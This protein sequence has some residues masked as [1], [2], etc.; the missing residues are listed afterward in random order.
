[1]QGQRVIMLH[2]PL[3]L[4]ILAVAGAFPDRPYDAMLGLEKG[5]KQ[6]RVWSCKLSGENAISSSRQFSSF[7]GSHS[8]GIGLGPFM[9]KSVLHQSKPSG[10][11][12]ASGEY[13]TWELFQ[14]GLGQQL[15]ESKDSLSEGARIYA[16]KYNLA[17]PGKSGAKPGMP[18]VQSA[19]LIPEVL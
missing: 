2:A 3:S 4:D 13:K 18:G 14:C 6:G 7:Q 11:S 1:M 9:P 10:G 5:Q 8:S 16:R 15:A 12:N 17:L 19:D